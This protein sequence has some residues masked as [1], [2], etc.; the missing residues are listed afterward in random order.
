MRVTAVW[1]CTCTLCL[2]SSA[3]MRAPS[4]GSM[5]GRTSGER[6]DLGDVQAAGG[7]SFGHLQ[8]DIAGADDQ[9][10][11]RLDGVE[12]VGER[13]CVANGVHQMYSVVWPE[14]VEAI[15]RWSDGYRSGADDDLVIA[16]RGLVA[17]SVLD[18]DAPAGR[19]RS[20]LRWCPVVAACRWHP[21]R[22]S[23]GEPGCASA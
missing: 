9:R 1:V 23:C 19:R 17:V 4:S 15:D 5:V 10:R 3:C 20:R 7:E 21:G 18:G 6:L 12:G 22:R 16:D 8:T 11:G 2:V 14:L 13:E